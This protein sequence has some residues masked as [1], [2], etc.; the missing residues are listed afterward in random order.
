METW[1]MENTFSIPGK[2]MEFEKKPQIPGKIME[3][4]KINLEKS[5]NSVS[6]LKHCETNFSRA[7]LAFQVSITIHAFIQDM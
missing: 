1:N 5:W 3:F 6:D 7:M 4:E 2:I